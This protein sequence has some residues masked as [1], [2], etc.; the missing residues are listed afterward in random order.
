MH[1]VVTWF[2]ETSKRRTDAETPLKTLA[3][4]TEQCSVKSEQTSKKKAV[5]IIL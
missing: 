1:D 2:H 5:C 4:W 3:N